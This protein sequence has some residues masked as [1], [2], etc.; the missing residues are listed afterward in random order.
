MIGPVIDAGRVVDLAVGSGTNIGIG[1]MARMVDG[2]HSVSAGG[3]GLSLERLRWPSGGHLG[4]HHTA[5]VFLDR[6]HLDGAI[7]QQHTDGRRLR[8]GLNGLDGHVR[9]GDQPG[10]V[11]VRVGAALHPGI[12]DVARVIGGVLPQEVGDGNN[13]FVSQ[14]VAGVVHDLVGEVGVGSAHVSRFVNE[15]P[16][17]DAVP[18]LE[19]IQHPSPAEG[20]P[21]RQGGIV[22]PLMD[23][24]TG[25]SPV[26]VEGDD[27]VEVAPDGV[28]QIIVA[29]P[30]FGGV[31]VVVGGTVFV[32]SKGEG[33]A[34]ELHPRRSLF[35]AISGHFDPVGVPF[36][37]LR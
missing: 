25:V 8:A 31:A 4:G 36:V 2:R 15:D 29:G 22:K 13:T 17:S 14:T 27:I 35:D 28:G 18:P 26:G 19:E 20:V 33:R 1:V 9:H 11:I 34:N 24:A 5:Q 37:E 3:D 7:I 23:A 16:G 10:D 30:S 21:A 6:Q 12:H 32:V